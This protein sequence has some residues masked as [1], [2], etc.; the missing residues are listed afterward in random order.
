[1]PHVAAFIS[2]HFDSVTSAESKR[3]KEAADGLAGMHASCMVQMVI[4]CVVDIISS[5][6]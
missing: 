1:M 3:L 6:F 2:I 5:Q 4:L